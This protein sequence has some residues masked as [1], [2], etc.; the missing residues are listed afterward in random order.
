MPRARTPW[1]VGHRPIARTRGLGGAADSYFHSSLQPLDVLLFVLPLIVLY[2]IG[3]AMFLARAGGQ[4]ET[5][6]AHSLLLSFF[7]DFG[8][9]GRAVPSCVIIA[10]LLSWHVM[11]GARWRVRPM[12]LAGMAL[13]A[14]A[15]TI[16]LLVLIALVLM[17][18]RPPAA[19]G[20]VDLASFPWQA[21][22]TISIG[23][24][25]YEEFLFRLVG[26]TLVH[27]I[28][29]DLL[30][31]PKSWATPIAILVT[32]VAFALYHDVAAAGGQ[33]RLAEL[34][35]L[36]VAGVFFGVVFYY[37]GFGIVA[38]VHTLYDIWVLIGMNRG[39]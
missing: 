19:A 3:S 28:L 20:G 32:G 7:R 14:A 24:G 35:A 30:R 25:L 1:P 6:R 31:A 22:A 5:I 16:P 36:G 39:G 23:A 18:G 4:V 9:V 29:T 12:V 8:V 10:T 15:W 33:A 38:M 2:E 21:R 37:R 27:A 17:F 34:V 11:S 13:E 26:L